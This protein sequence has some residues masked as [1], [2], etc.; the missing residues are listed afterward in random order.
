MVVDFKVI[1]YDLIIVNVNED[2]N[3]KLGEL[4]ENIKI[5]YF[6]ESNENSFSIST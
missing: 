5:N 2:L 3:I 4:S 1:N 6:L